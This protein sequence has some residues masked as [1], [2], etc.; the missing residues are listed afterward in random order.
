MNPHLLHLALLVLFTTMICLPVSGVD[1]ARAQPSGHFHFAGEP[2]QPPAAA[3]LDAAGELG[4]QGQLQGPADAIRVSD[5]T[6]HPYVYN[7]G[8][9][10]SEARQ[11]SL[12]LR[13]SGNAARHITAPVDVAPDGSFTLEAIVRNGENLPEPGGASM[14]I[15][16]WRSA[17]GQQSV[18]LQVYS[19]DGYNWWAG[20]VEHG[21]QTHRLSQALYN[22]WTHVRSPQWRHLA[23]VYDAPTQTVTS[24]LD[25]T[26]L[27][28]VKLE[29]PL[30]LAD[31]AL[32]IGDGPENTSDRRFV[33]HVGDVR[34]T[35]AG[36]APWE[37]L[38]ATPHDLEHANF[39]PQPGLL[40]EGSGYV[41][42]RL[43][44]G[45]VGD[46]VHDDTHAFKRAFAELQ[47]RVPIEYH[48]LYIPEG[49]Y[50]ISEPVSWTRF[51]IVQGAGP[52][53]TVLRL[54]DNAAGFDNPAQAN[55][56]LYVGWDSYRERANGQGSA[57][58][59]IGSY[60]FGLTLDTGRGNPGAV[61]LA[62]HSNNHGAIERVAIRS[63]DGQGHRGLDFSMNWPGPTL[64]KHVSVDGF[65]TGIYSRAGEYSLVFEHVELRD[66]RRL[67]IHNEGNIL[68][69]RK[70]TSVNNV[71]AIRT[72]G[73]GM[74]TLIDSELRAPANTDLT[75]I[76][77]SERGA[78]Y[79]RNVDTPGYRRA[80]RSDR[81]T[82]RGGHVPAFLPGRPQG[83]FDAPPVT[84]DLPIEETPEIPLGDDSIQW[85][86]VL[87]FADHVEGNWWD[88]DWAPAIQAAF[89]SGAEAIFFPANQ[90]EGYGVRST[91]EVPASVHYLLGMQTGI[92]RHGEFS[93]PTVRIAGDNEHPLI[94]ERFTVAGELEHSSPRTVVFRHGGPKIYQARP[95]AGHV[96]FED[97]ES[98]TRF[99][100]GQKA[101]A[102]Q[103]NPESHDVSELI[104]DGGDVW[105]LGLK[106]EYA[107][108]MVV[109]RNGGRLEV[110]GGFLYPVTEVPP[111]MPMVLT[112]DA[113]TAM[114]FS[115]TAYN[116]DFR[117]YFRDIQHGET[118]E[119]LNE[120]IDSKGARRHVH[121][122][123]TEPP[124]R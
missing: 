72:G 82:V 67:A 83:L 20:A 32:H 63:E 52:D 8:T 95:G 49:T 116:H 103:L 123:T 88:G 70:L 33:G 79:V 21:G 29:G 61:G 115:T 17:D 46:G 26:P 3:A 117:I 107:S 43:R 47:D 56:L 109:N 113:R 5:Q 2:G 97:S 11:T 110:L 1:E 94:L 91:V 39:Q 9:G 87:E 30:E 58:N 15:V 76:E 69:I 80:I 86:S 54:K 104:N 24:Y 102:R 92:G 124:P 98:Y 90:G 28:S 41:D 37:L 65:D 6:P 122:Y 48:T 50:V 7:P 60:L 106:T 93:G 100:D 118:R 55:A 14:E 45:A 68:S 73:W 19:S 34:L 53:K 89:D 35:A 51:L 57:G 10:Q 27:D 85:V 99:A 119:L 120:A 22:G 121:L 75:A 84:L 12:E 40:P 108:T 66:Q 4:L 101:W 71:P 38:R 77:N 64:I 23:V 44:Y 105:V 111:D 36:L 31:G 42:L 78:L 18:S 62:F 25:Y 114:I 74:V 59:A 81:E 112:E 13:P 96:F 16:T